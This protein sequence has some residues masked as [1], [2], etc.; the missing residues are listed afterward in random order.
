MAGTCTHGEMQRIT[1][2]RRHPMGDKKG[3]KD[4]AKGQRQQ[5]AKKAKTAKQK[6]DRQKPRTP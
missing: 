6:Q 3:K 4:K 1:P 2:E 5:A